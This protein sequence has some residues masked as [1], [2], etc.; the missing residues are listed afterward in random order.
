HQLVMSDVIGDQLDIIGSGLLVPSNHTPLS[1]KIPD[2]IQNLINKAPPTPDK[3]FPVPDTAILANNLTAMQEAKEKALSLGMTVFLH[4]EPLI[5][6]VQQVADRLSCYINTAQQ[7]LHVFGGEPVINLPAHAG[8]GGRMQALALLLAQAIAR[9]DDVLV[10]CGSTDGSDGSG[11]DAGALVDGTTL[12]RG[13]MGGF[14]IDDCIR[15]AD[16]GS[17]LEAAG[18][19]IQTGPTG[20]NVNDLVL[21]LIK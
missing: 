19:L 21:V 16:A 7:G 3:G 18:D 1:S 12:E 11:E 5:D 13:E 2:W 6:E 9:R 20:S 15:R 17:F 4:P 14:D 10:L 8:R